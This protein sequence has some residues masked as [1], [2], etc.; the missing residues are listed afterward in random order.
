MIY[1]TPVVTVTY[2]LGETSGETS[3]ELL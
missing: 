3:N 1:K 2:L